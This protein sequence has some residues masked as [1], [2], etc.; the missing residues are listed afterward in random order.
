MV[1]SAMVSAASQPYFSSSLEN[2]CSQ[3]LDCALLLYIIRTSTGSNRVLLSSAIT[4]WSLSWLSTAKIFKV[5]FCKPRGW[6]HAR[7]CGLVWR[8][9]DS[10]YGY[11]ELSYSAFVCRVECKSAGS[12]QHVCRA[13]AYVVRSRLCRSA[14]RKGSVFACR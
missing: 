3:I 14:L 7:Y 6:V 10:A 2:P 13:R 1:L 8:L 9:A 11:Q 12:T 5:A 4:S